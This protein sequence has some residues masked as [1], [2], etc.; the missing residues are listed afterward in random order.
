M[1]IK[2]YPISKS[3]NYLYSYIFVVNIHNSCSKSIQTCT[4]ISIA[5]KS[6]L[7]L[8]RVRTVIV[9]ANSVDVTGM[10]LFRTL[11]DVWITKLEEG[12]AT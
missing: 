11:V 3:T 12:I 2:Y 10:A 7:A 5:S 9:N 4:G 6:G 1:I 8:T